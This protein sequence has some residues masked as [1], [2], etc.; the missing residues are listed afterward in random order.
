MEKKEGNLKFN[1]DFC[2]NKKL[3]KCRL[4]YGQFDNFKIKIDFQPF[5]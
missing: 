5:K 2:D 4:G 1:F 3:A